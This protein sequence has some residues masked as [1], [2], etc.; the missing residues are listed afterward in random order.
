MLG[1]TEAV[2][3]RDALFISM[4]AAPAACRAMR[5][6]A[7]CKVAA[8]W[9]VSC[10]SGI[11]GTGGK[12]VGVVEEGVDGKSGCGAGQGGESVE[13]SNGCRVGCVVGLRQCLM[14][15][16]KLKGRMCPLC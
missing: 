16:E 10:A 14:S 3:Q 6:I 13:G 15:L 12:T 1:E 2:N 4:A 8:R 9:S 5:S 7:C 11:G